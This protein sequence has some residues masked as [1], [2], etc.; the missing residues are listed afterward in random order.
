MQRTQRTREKYRKELTELQAERKA[1]REAELEEAC[2]LFRL[3]EAEGVEFD[4]E[5]DSI[6]F[7]SRRSN[8]TPAVMTA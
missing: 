2:L 8:A 1:H 7:L 3:A 5:A 6:V 4:P